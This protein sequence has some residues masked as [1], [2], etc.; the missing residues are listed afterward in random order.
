MGDD[1]PRLAICHSDSVAN[2]VHF[3]GRCR[4]ST[5]PARLL[6][7]RAIFSE[8]SVWEG[9]GDGWRHLHRSF[10][11]LRYSIE[12]HDFTTARELNWARRCP[13]ANIFKPWEDW[14]RRGR[15]AS[16][17]NTS[18]SRSRLQLRIERGRPA[19]RGKT[20]HNASRAGSRLL[21]PEPLQRGVSRGFGCC[22]GL[23]PVQNP[24]QRTFEGKPCG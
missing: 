4:V 9:I 23:Y 20:E 18:L 3:A 15:A 24:T 5:I 8:L 21:Q 12:W 7:R 10:R 1:P 16:G 11:D 13:P 22:P 19:A 2:C 17:I 6:P 14:P